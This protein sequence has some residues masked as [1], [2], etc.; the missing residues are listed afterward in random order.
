MYSDDRA[1]FMDISCSNPI[2]NVYSL[3]VQSQGSYQGWFEGEI[4][5]LARSGKIIWRN[6]SKLENSFH[7]MVNWVITDCLVVDWN[8]K[9]MEISWLLLINFNFECEYAPSFIVNF[10]WN[11][12]WTNNW[13][14]SHFRKQELNICLSS[15]YRL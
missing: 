1:F 3:V 15:E 5:S 10:S 2:T 12:S 14:K 13:Q 6:R 8:I 7:F 4:L 9:N 11:F